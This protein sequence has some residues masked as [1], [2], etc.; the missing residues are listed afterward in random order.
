MLPQADFLAEARRVVEAARE[1]GLTLRIMGAVAFRLHCPANESLHRTL[2][3]EISDLDFVGQRS[4]RRQIEKL[5]LS[6]GYSVHEQALV[7]TQGMAPNRLFL[8]DKHNRRVV[9]IFFD[10]L[11]MCHRISFQNRLNAD[12]PTIPL[13]ELLLE[14]LQIVHLN[15]KD[16]KDTIVLLLEHPIGD[17]DHESVNGKYIAELLSED[18]GF[19]YTATENLKKIS[20]AAKSFNALSPEQQ[21]TVE[22]RVSELTSIVEARPK[23][24]KWKMRA[25]IG[26]KMKWYNDVEEIAR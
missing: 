26:T 14:K 2:E 10:E 6:L 13:A 5:M 15:Q 19:Y 1:A 24:S 17:D 9:D 18:W 23:S 11:Y 21:R 25:R 16:I 22:N 8:Y 12:F 3:R 20:N 7:E 4:E